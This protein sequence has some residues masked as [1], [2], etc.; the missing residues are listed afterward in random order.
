MIINHDSATGMA[1][2]TCKGGGAAVMKINS[3]VV[4]ALFTKDKPCQDNAGNNLPKT[5]QTAGNCADQVLTMG[6]YLKDQGY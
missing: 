5:F 6:N 3:A 1:Q 2:L 4:I